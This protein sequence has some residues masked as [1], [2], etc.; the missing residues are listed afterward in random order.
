[1]QFVDDILP[2]VVQAGAT[3]LYRIARHDWLGAGLTLAVPLILLDS[4]LICCLFIGHEQPTKE[5]QDICHHRRHI[6][7][8]IRI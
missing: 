4:S 7:D 1:M 6:R 2:R 5:Q 3:R 8:P